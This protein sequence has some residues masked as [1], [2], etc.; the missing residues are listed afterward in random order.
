MGML[1]VM[2]FSVLGLSTGNIFS[3]LFRAFWKVASAVTGSE[4][5]LAP[6]MLTVLELVCRGV[7]N[8]YPGLPG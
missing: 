6:G 1:R 8:Q 5:V 3:D 4:Q 2:G 7:V